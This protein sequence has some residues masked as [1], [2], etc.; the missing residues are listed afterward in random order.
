MKE[1]IA[2]SKEELRKQTGREAD[3]KTVDEA[4]GPKS[5]CKC[6]IKRKPKLSRP[7]GKRLKFIGFVEKN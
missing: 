5:S 2:R 1:N 6:L 7:L 3:K 4:T